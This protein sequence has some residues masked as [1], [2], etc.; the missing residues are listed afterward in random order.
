VELVLALP[1]G[2]EAV[3]ELAETRVTPS[4]AMLAGLE[5]LFGQSVAE[6]R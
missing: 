6:L 3:L 1:E 4:D 2:A 5:R